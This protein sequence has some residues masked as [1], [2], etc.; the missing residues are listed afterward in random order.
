MDFQNSDDLSEPA[1]NATDEDR[2]GLEF[3]EAERAQTSEPSTH[4][5][6]QLAS[7]LKEFQASTERALYELFKV[8][9]SRLSY[10]ETKEKAFDR[11]YAELEE[12]KQD[13][14][15]EQMRPFI[16]DLIL[17]FDRLDHMRSEPL[18]TDGGSPIVESILGELLEILS[19]R[20]VTMTPPTEHFDPTFQHALGTEKTSNQGKNNCIARIVRRGFRYNAKVLR[21]EEVFVY[22]FTLGGPDPDVEDSKGESQIERITDGT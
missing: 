18:G 17:L 4:W 15:F 16:T 20:G 19:R 5:S 3:P 12:L 7:Q 2:H 1:E 22:R 10:D 21:H 9:E 13:R 6:N 11:L 8:V 14:E